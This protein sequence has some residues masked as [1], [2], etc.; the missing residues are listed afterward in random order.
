MLISIHTSCVASSSPSSSSVGATPRDF[1]AF[2]KAWHS[3]C[4][5]KEEELRRELGHLDKGLNKLDS[6]AEVVHDLKTNAHQQEKDLRV[7]QAAAD[8]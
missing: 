4:V 3:L 2:L 5:T 1:F 7:A 8:R 6:A